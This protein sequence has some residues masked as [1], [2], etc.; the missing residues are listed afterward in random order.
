MTDKNAIG[1]TIIGHNSEDRRLVNGY[2]EP[3]SYVRHVQ[4]QG[5]GIT[6]VLQIAVITNF[7][8]HCEQF[9]KYECYGSVLFRYGSPG[10]WVSRNSAKMTHWGGATQANSYKCACGVTIPNTCANPT[11]GCNCDKNDLVWREDS[12]LLTEKSY[13]PVTQMRFGDTGSSIE[14][15][16][17]TLG[18]FK[19]Y[20]MA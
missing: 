3:G 19:C 6:S 9:I 15:G 1:V 17:H 18:K 8:T 5:A 7:S 16:Y 11:Y 14:K 4:Y 10:Y 20:G 12:G 13:L 2:E